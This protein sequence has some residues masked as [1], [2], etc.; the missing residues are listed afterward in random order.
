MEKMLLLDWAKLAKIDTRET[1]IKTKD[2]IESYLI[3]LHI[4]SSSAIVIYIVH[5]NLILLALIK[6]MKTY[7]CYLCKWSN[8]K[9]GNRWTKIYIQNTAYN[10]NQVINICKKLYLYNVRQLEHVSPST[11]SYLLYIR[12]YTC[13]T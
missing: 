12:L 7:V 9:Q 11:I 5:C 3:L 4:K 6:K 10:Q 2:E 1:W 8:E 13:K